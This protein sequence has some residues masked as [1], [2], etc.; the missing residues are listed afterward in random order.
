MTALAVKNQEEHLE[1][2]LKKITKYENFKYIT[3]K[4]MNY[5]PQDSI[6]GSY[7]SRYVL[8]E[9][10]AACDDVGKASTYNLLV[11]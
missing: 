11:D 7:S 2:I 9:V 3:R 8:N 4:R 1:K 10:F 5:M 6:T